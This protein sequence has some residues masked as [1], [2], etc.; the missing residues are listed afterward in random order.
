MLSIGTL[1]LISLFAAIALWSTAWLGH[2]I[3]LV[4][5]PSGRKNHA[6]EIPLT[7]GLAIFATLV[8]HDR[9]HHHF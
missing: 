3:D 2:R 8:G 9:R 4:D 7:G 5:R 1:A 6:G